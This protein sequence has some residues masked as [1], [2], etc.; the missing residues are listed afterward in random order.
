MYLIPE[1][2]DLLIRIINLQVNH[3]SLLPNVVLASVR[4][5]HQAA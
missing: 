5:Q 2:P 1:N 4:W 3:I